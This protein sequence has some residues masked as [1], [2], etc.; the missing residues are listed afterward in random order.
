MIGIYKITNIANNKIYIG[1]SNDINRRWRDHLNYAQT[2]TAREYNTP[3]HRAIRKYGSENFQLEIL[4]ITTIELLNKQEQ[5]W[6]NIFK[7]NNSQVG[8]NLTYGGNGR[9]GTTRTINQYD[10]LGNFIQT[11]DSPVVAANSLGITTYAIKNCCYYP[12]KYKSAAQYQWKFTDD[13]RIIS[14]YQRNWDLSGLEKGHQFEGKICLQYDLQNN[15][16]QTF[17][18]RTEAV[19]WLKENGFPTASLSYLGKR[20]KLNKPVYG[21]YWKGV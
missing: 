10:L 9:I 21:F 18:S 2:P 20:I 17:N 8:Y 5:Y 1:Q 7:S 12:E 16:L 4:E 11:W 3:I 14:I 13:N 6:I 15:L 19:S